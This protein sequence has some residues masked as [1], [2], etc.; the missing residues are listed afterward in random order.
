[1]LNTNNRLVDLVL[2]N[3][4]C[5]VTHQIITVVEEDLHHPALLAT[6]QC[7]S[8][9]NNNF[10]NNLIPK[11]VPY[12]FRKANFGVLYILLKVDWDFQDDVLDVN[13]SC[14]LFYD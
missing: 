3:I 11:H 10:P 8:T 13:D 7:L 5:I 6:Q 9:N 4:Y 1:M 2:T 12:N 14:N